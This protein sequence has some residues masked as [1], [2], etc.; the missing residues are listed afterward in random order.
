MVIDL[1]NC[2]VFLLD[3]YSGPAGSPG[4]VNHMG[5]YTAGATTMLVDTFTG[6]VATGDT[7]TVAGD[8][9]AS[10]DPIVH[11]ITAHT[12]TSMATTSITFTPAVVGTVA[13]NA[14][15]TILPH[16]IKVRIGE[17]N[18]QFTEKRAITYVKDRG[19]LDTVKLGD[20]DPVEVKLDFTW[21]F[22]TAQGSEPATVE[23]V[24][25]HRGPAAGWVSSSADPCEPYCIEIQVVFVPPCPT[26]GETYILAD[27]RY[28]ELGHDFKTGAVS[29]SGKCNIVATT[30]TR[31]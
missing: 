1:K 29:V 10:M 27:F 30:S 25:K 18:C 4:L 13:D 9:D 28:E 8:V 20:Q 2:N 16:S 11:T 5:G 19:L 3:G 17:G 15:I 6:A 26:P 12:E 22:L 14:V 31:P 7:F 23:D 24:L 21:Q